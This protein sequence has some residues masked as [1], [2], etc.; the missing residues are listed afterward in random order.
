MGYAII[1]N[2][3]DNG[4]TTDDFPIR[5]GCRISVVC[6][7]HICGQHSTQLG[8]MGYEFCRQRLRLLQAAVLIVVTITVTTEAKSGQDLFTKQTVQALHIHTDMIREGFTAQ[9]GITVKSGKNYGAAQV[10][11]LCQ[12]RTRRK[13]VTVT[14][15]MEQSMQRIACRQLVCRLSQQIIQFSG[16]HAMKTS[17]KA[18]QR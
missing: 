17:Q 13:R 1:G 15:F 7:L 3:L 2:G 6:R 9:G 5:F 10:Y 14:M 4:I 16:I 18:M 8:Q 11:N 12:Y